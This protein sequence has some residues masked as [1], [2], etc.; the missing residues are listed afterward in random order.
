MKNLE[1][2]KKLVPLHPHL[3]KSPEYYQNPNVLERW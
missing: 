2:K 3:G 1:Y